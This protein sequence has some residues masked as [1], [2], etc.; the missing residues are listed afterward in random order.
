MCSL[1]HKVPYRI[2]VLIKLM[3]LAYIPYI[4]Y[5]ISLSL[6]YNSCSLFISN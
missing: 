4:A 2:T 5:I 6:S 1:F 3:E